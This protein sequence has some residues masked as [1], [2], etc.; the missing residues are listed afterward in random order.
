M[1][2]PTGTILVIDGEAQIRRSIGAGLALEGYA[3]HEAGSGVAGLSAAE[4][5]RPELIVLELGLP[6]M[7]GIEVLERIRSWSTVPVI[8]LSVE[9]DEEQKVR[10]LKG[11]ADDYV[12]KPF[13]IAEFLARCEAKLRRYDKDAD[14]SPIV[15]TG[16][17]TIGLAS[18]AVVLDGVRLTLSRNEYRLLSLLAAHLGHVVMHK[19]LVGDIWRR[20]PSPDNIQLLRLLVSRLRQKIESDPGQPKFVISEPEAGYRLDRLAV[21]RT[22]E[23]FEAIET[24]RASVIWPESA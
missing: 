19:Q 9:T 23:T 4:H 5:V 10:L 13:G 7:S 12:V 1:R 21:P 8:V 15:R 16:P 24:P 14:C 2:K 18:R 3:V 6:D 20:S 22:A 11:G 17:L